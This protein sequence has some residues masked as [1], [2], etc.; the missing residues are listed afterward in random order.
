MKVSRHKPQGR[1]CGLGASAVF[2]PSSCVAIAIAVPMT[3]TGNAL[4]ELGQRET[5]ILWVQYSKALTSELRVVH[6]LQRQGDATRQVRW[7]CRMHSEKG[8]A[9]HRAHSSFVLPTAITLQLPLTVVGG[10]VP[11]TLAVTALAS[12]EPS[13]RQR[14]IGQNCVAASQ[15]HMRRTPRASQSTTSSKVTEIE[16]GADSSSHACA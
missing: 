15:C 8:L 4:R 14:L 2:R 9:L 12:A 1:G 7:A 10:A 3:D 13:P 11:R 16:S 6:C 5:I